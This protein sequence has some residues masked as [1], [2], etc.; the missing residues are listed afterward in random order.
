MHTISRKTE[1]YRRKV[2][3]SW[4][5]VGL[6]VSSVDLGAVPKSTYWAKRVVTSYYFGT[7]VFQFVSRIDARIDARK[8]ENNVFDISNHANPPYCRK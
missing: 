8:H 4:S 2:R 3:Q 6:R 7:I 5:K 1:V